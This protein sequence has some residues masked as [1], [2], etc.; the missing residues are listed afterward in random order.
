MIFPGVSPLGDLGLD[1]SANYVYAT[2]AITAGAALAPLSALNDT[3]AQADITTDAVVDAL[4]YLS[5]VGMHL[6]AATPAG[7]SLSI[8]ELLCEQV[9]TAEVQAAASL[10]IVSATGIARR[11]GISAGSTVYPLSPSYLPAK[12]ALLSGALLS[13]FASRTI[14]RQASLTAAAELS[15]VGGRYRHAAVHIE[16][17]ATVR[18]VTGRQQLRAPAISASAVV[19]PVASKYES[20]TVALQGNA[21]LA[22]IAMDE[23]AA[24]AVIQAEATVSPSVELG[25]PQD[26]VHI[27][28]AAVVDASGSSV[29]EA[30]Y[31][32]LDII[33]VMQRNPALHILSHE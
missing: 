6:T 3:Y 14:S 28:A 29:V 19:S 10:G 4:P 9:A 2:V 21:S 7:A 17:R 27:V 33:T 8:L 12:P 5:P 26:Q 1:E 20:A 18:A 30:I 13:V 11:G 25:F 23:K 32:D 22:L 24:T 15:L 16:A 31:E